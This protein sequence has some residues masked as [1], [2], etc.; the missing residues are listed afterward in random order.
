[1]PHLYAAPGAEADER[2]SLGSGQPGERC[3]RNQ[4]IGEQIVWL[5]PWKSTWSVLFPRLVMKDKDL[6]ER[7]GELQLIH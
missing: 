1:M 7:E 3:G 5:P 6:G 2:V 4:L